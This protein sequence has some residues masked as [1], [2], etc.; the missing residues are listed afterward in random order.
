MG[1]AGYFSTTA[2]IKDKRTPLEAALANV[3]SLE[4]L[5]LLEKVTKNSAVQPAEEKYRRLKLSN[6]KIR[7][8]VAEVEGGLEAMAALGWQ[9]V[10]EE[11]EEV[12]TLAKGAA[13][14]AQ[15][16][17]ILEAQQEFKKNDRQ[18]KRAKSSAS[19]PGSDEQAALRA[20]IEADRL[21]RAA[22]SPVA[23]D[24]VAQALP[25]EGARIA[26]A[27]DCGIQCEC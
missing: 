10:Q 17:C 22:R 15:V 23:K 27:K 12:L 24:S 19:L 14:M 18:L 3:G 1:Y 2:R 16:R 20:Q 13:T 26:T 5:E 9:Q 11:G 8:L 7:S 25:G 21:E 6:A 4:T